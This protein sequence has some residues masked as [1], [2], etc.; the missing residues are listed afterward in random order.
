MELT[1][2]QWAVLAP[3]IPEPRREDGRGRP[4][5]A[6]REVLDGIMWV[7]R[8]G[9]QWADLPGRYPPYQTCHR[10]L[11]EWVGDGVLKRVLEALAQDLEER[12]E[13]DLSE[14][15]IDGTFVAAKKGGQ[16]SV[17]LSGARVAKSWR[18]RTLLVLASPSTLTLLHRMR[19]RWYTRLSHLDTSAASPQNLWAT[20]RMT[21]IR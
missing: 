17:R 8:T 15:F 10:R 18:Y 19:S 14:C 5:R 6:N 3:L 11:Q 12:G 16:K 7:L 9:A 4:R 21:A 1:D 20:K 13:L 2:E